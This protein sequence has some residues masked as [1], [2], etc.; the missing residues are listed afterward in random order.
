[1]RKLKFLK[2]NNEQYTNKNFHGTRDYYNLIKSVLTT[3]TN[4]KD[5]NCINEVFFS[6]EIYYLGSL[7][8]EDKFNKVYS[9]KVIT[10][11]KYYLEQSIILILKN[12]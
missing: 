11:I 7:F 3:F 12:L 10:K 9:T 8:E 1:M 2:L 4:K 5:C 6:I